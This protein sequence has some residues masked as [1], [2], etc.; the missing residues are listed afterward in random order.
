[1]AE[2]LFQASRHDD[3]VRLALEGPEPAVVRDEMLRLQVR[4]RRIALALRAAAAGGRQDEALRLTLLAAEAARSNTALKELLRERPELAFR[5]GDPRTVVRLYAQEEPWHGSVHFRTAALYARDPG[6]HDR[7]DEQLRMAWAWVKRLKTLPKSEAYN[8]RLDAEDVASSVIATFYLRGP[9]EAKKLLKNWRPRS[10][11][12]KVL[13]YIATAF[14]S[15][16]GLAE[17]EDKL[18]LDRELPWG[19]AAFIVALWEAGCTPTPALVQ[20][21]A[22]RLEQNVQRNKR[23]PALT[24]QAMPALS[25]CSE[26]RLELPIAPVMAEMT[27]ADKSPDRAL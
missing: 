14:A 27:A 19:G 22:G 5:Y 18:S 2:H 25:T 9:E 20:R 13:P 26:E 12:F 17:L 15:H 6:Q 16:V 4:R 1:M 8:W 10:I 11:V 3:V 24:R 23:H 7:A 21:V